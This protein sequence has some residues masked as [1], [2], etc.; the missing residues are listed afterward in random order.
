M[1]LKV[2]HKSL[3]TKN[4]KEDTKDAKKT[5]RATGPLA[6]RDGANGAATQTPAIERL[7]LRRRCRHR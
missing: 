7:W 3:N 5:E 2:G 6:G 4:T 1:K